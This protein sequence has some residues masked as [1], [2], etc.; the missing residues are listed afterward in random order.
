MSVTRNCTRCGADT[1]PTD[2]GRCPRCSTAFGEATLTQ[3]PPG[4]SRDSAPPDGG[5]SVIIGLGAMAGIVALV[6]WLFQLIFGT[7]WGLPM[8]IAAVVAVTIVCIIAPAGTRGVA[9][10]V[11]VIAALYVLGLA[12][13]S[14]ADGPDVAPAE[15]PLRQGVEACLDGRLPANVDTQ[16]GLGFCDTVNQIDDDLYGG[17]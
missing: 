6:A 15:S 17:G 1:I 7:W 3:H 2:Q 11:S 16:T 9:G 14:A 4:N 5:L 8:V 13:P 10:T 12:V